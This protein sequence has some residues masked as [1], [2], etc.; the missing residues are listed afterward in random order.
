MMCSHCVYS[1][2]CK[3]IVGRTVDLYK[4]TSNDNDFHGNLKTCSVNVLSSC[5]LAYMK[6]VYMC[7]VAVY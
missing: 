5:L 2:L 7:I 3:A 1:M 6:R 4:C